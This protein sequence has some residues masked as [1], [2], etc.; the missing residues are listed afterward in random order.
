MS[1][2]Q[3]LGLGLCAVGVSSI[4]GYYY[5]DK[6]RQE[7]RLEKAQQREERKETVQNMKD[8]ITTTL[9]E[10]KKNKKEQQ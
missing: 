9:S 7:R 8:K 6:W 2:L 10:N 5:K 3:L 4:V 1:R